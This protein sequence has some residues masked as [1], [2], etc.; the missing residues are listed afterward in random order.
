MAN[1]A[2]NWWDKHEMDKDG[3]GCCLIFMVLMLAVFILGGSFAAFLIWSIF[4]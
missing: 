3:K 4:L 1:F 2:R